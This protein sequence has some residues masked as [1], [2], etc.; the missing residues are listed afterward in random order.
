MSAAKAPA[1][2]FFRTRICK[3]NKVGKCTKGDKCQ[4]AHDRR[5]QNA[6]KLRSGP[7]KQC[8]Y[9]KRGDCRN[10]EDCEFVHGLPE[11]QTTIIPPTEEESLA[12]DNVSTMHELSPAVSDENNV[13]LETESV[14]TAVQETPRSLPLVTQKARRL[15]GWDDLQEDYSDCELPL[16][17]RADPEVHPAAP[18]A[19]RIL[20]GGTEA[21]ASSNTEMQPE[22]ERTPEGAP[23]L[24]E[25]TTYAA[26]VGG[27]R[28]RLSS[29]R[30]S[31][32]DID[33]DTDDEDYKFEWSQPAKH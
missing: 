29:M 11:K 26:E 17:V 21:A 6:Q 9:F 12:A 18:A 33:V 19:A 15:P 16:G 14:K 31:W 5:T 28:E 27:G 7:R 32:A 20:A 30:K 2:I 25:N 1:T 23:E 8:K 4:W 13:S 10:G 24:V 3:Y 22:A